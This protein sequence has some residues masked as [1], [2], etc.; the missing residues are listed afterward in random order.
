MRSDISACALNEPIYWCNPRVHPANHTKT[1]A[2][3]PEPAVC[4]A[5]KPNHIFIRPNGMISKCTSALDREDNNIGHL[6]PTGEIEVDDAKALAW[7]FG[8]KTEQAQDLSCPYWTK[9]QEQVI[10]FM[11]RP[12]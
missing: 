12:S 6:L 1:D 7:S 5:A 11:P 4:Y 9:P 8:F 3:E 2:L 10:T